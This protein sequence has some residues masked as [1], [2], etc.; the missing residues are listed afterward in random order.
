MFQKT[1]NISVLNPKRGGESG[2]G[3]GS[4]EIEG[5]FNM[6][7]YVLKPTPRAHTTDHTLTGRQA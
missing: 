1:L 7:K 2:E 3:I 6:L 5:V 4:I